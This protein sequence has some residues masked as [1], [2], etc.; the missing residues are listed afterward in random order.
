MRLRSSLGAFAVLLMLTALLLP[1]PAN[2]DETKLLAEGQSWT[3][4]PNVGTV[5]V[6]LL[7]VSMKARITGTV[8]FKSTT[9]GSEKTVSLNTSFRRS[10]R[11]TSIITMTAMLSRA[12]SSQPN[13]AMFRL[14][15]CTA[16]KACWAARFGF[17]ILKERTQ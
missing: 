15:P 12:S 3:I 7:A 1:G 14:T 16:T 13:R 4:E 5:D 9:D 11:W 6:T 17:G 10:S 8:F 2:A